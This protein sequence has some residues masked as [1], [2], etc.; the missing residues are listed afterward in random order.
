MTSEPQKE[1]A[2]GGLLADGEEEAGA[3]GAETE[4][5][6]LPKSHTEA[7]H[8]QRQSNASEEGQ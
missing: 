8:Q 7:W 5:K 3:Q 1:R 2:Q 6:D 4:S